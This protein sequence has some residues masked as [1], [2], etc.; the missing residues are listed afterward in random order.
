MP[1]ALSLKHMRMTFLAGLIL[2]ACAVPFASAQT[3]D[4]DTPGEPPLLQ[5]LRLLPDSDL[6]RI[7]D[8][9]GW[10]LSYVNFRAV[11]AAQ[12]APVRP[13]DFAQVEA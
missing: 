4:T 10:Y 7:E 13:V 2:L 3:D 11:E 5:A 1:N 12:P 8:S 9:R 6:V